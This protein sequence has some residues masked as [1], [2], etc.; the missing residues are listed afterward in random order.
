MALCTHC[1][2]SEATLQCGLCEKGEFQKDFVVGFS[3]IPSPPF[4]IVDSGSVLCQ[5]CSEKVHCDVDH[6]QAISPLRWSEIRA[7]A[8][9]ELT[10]A[11]Q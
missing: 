10:E 9:E 2:V 3:I 5:Q 1:G 6:Q 4:S 11:S 7:A 8:A